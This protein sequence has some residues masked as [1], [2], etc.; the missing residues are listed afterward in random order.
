MNCKEVIKE[1]LTTNGFDGLT[2]PAGDCG[3]DLDSL[4]CCVNDC[5]D[6]TPGY[7]HPHEDFG[8]VIK[9]GPY[10]PTEERIDNLKQRVEIQCRP[11]NW[12]FD[13]YMHGMAN[14]LIL[15]LAT[16]QGTGVEYLEAPVEWLVDLEGPE[17]SENSC[18]EESFDEFTHF[19]EGC[20]YEFIL[21]GALINIGRCERKYNN[22]L[23]SPL[24]VKLFLFG[25]QWINFDSILPEYKVNRI[26]PSVVRRR[27]IQMGGEI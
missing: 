11:G 21:N 18:D 8:F 15:G 23:F 9:H 1:Y 13:P 19:E 20:Y 7:K 16:I 2:D 12:N 25:N 27:I 5:S 26:C 22:G 10:N 14:G 6:C 4:V 3:C 24:G 17:N